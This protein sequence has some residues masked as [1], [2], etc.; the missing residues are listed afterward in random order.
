MANN[1]LEQARK[2]TQEARERYEDNQRQQAEA[3]AKEAEG[4]DAEQALDTQDV[5]RDET[6]QSQS[7]NA[8]EEEDKA[9]APSADA[10]IKE[11]ERQVESI[12]RNYDNLRSYADR[13]AGENSQLKREN[14][15]LNSQLQY[16]LADG[17]RTGNQPQGQ[18]QAQPR[19]AAVPQ[20]HAGESNQDYL[21]RLLE[22]HAD[23]KEANEDFPHLIQ[24][25]LRVVD[26]LRQEL[27]SRV[28]PIHQTMRDEI[29]LSQEERERTAEERQRQATREYFKAIADK[30]PDYRQVMEGDAFG[31]FLNNH[32]MGQTYASLLWPN[33][34]ERLATPAEV[35][36]ILDEFKE[37]SGSPANRSRQSREDQAAQRRNAAAADA[38]PTMRQSQGQ[39]IPTDGDYI[40]R[41][42]IIAWSKDPKLFR[43]NKERLNQ[44]MQQGRI[45]EDVAR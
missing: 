42:E 34:G 25:L 2:L 32:R 4:E 41:S 31:N 15:E 21:S 7:D 43:A 36:A 38:E 23:L 33:E 26:E 14:Q 10:R 28:D 35:N 24:P 40:K 19:D 13:T 9:P 6:E 20:K 16:L 17:Q 44:A 3:A 30:H 27:N 11:L 1:A 29:R 5:V 45:I 39:S 8:V 37:A 12:Q 22:H 18:G